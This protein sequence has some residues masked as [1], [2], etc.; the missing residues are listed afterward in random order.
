M[1]Y[2]SSLSPEE[3]YLLAFPEDVSG[4]ATQR[5]LMEKEFDSK[6]C[7]RK[8]MNISPLPQQ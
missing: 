3:Q 5:R 4:S 6:C 7:N 1:W 2:K 8:T